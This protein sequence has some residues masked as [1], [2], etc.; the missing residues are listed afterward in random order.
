MSI[1]VA[2]GAGYIGAHVVR[3][4]L[5]RGD[6]VIVVDDLSYGTPER[7]TGAA[8]VELDVASGGAVDALTDVMGRRGVNA[9]IHFAERREDKDGGAH[10]FL[11][12]LSDHGEAVHFGQHAVHDKD[13]VLAAL[14]HG[15]PF[16]AGMCGIDDVAAFAE[17]FGD[18]G[19]DVFVVFDDQN[20]HELLLIFL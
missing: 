6:E 14:R 16:A 12:Q 5:Q 4:L 7:V 20:V 15:K 9:V 10:A 17:S 19:G 1:L 3:L 18:V 13:V 11:A 2:G 8:L